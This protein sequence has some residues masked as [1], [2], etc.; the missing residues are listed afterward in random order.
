MY[1]DKEAYCRSLG[2]LRFMGELCRLEM[3]K[4]YIMHE[5]INVFLKDSFESCSKLLATCGK[6]LDTEEAKVSTE[7][8]IFD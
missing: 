5:C 8:N 4:E 6:Q 2:L 1:L 3:L 7:V